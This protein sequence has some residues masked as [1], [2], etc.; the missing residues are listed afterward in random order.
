MEIK[1]EGVDKMAIKRKLSKRYSLAKLPVGW[2][3]KIFFSIHSEFLKL[4]VAVLSA[5]G[6]RPS[7]IERGV[8]VRMF[9][10]H[11]TIGIEGAK[12]D[13]KSGR[14]QPMRVL[15]VDSTTPWGSYL[16]QY[17]AAHNI[18]VIRYDAGGISQRLREKS[19][20]LWPR[21]KSLISAYTYRHFVGKSM[22][23]S[24]E[25]PEKIASTLGH[26]TDYAQTMYGRA[27][28]ARKSSGQHGVQVARATN[29]IRHSKKTDRL[30]GFLN[31]Q[32][33]DN[34]SSI[35]GDQT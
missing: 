19:R 22:K 30:N 6:C 12:V 20:E 2:R 3:E 29:A 16:S 23:E 8:K 24:G 34:A 11:L 9:H 33:H 4:A 28:G 21:R 7:E 26:A 5:T 10:G 31:A 1:A 17:I 13:L 35:A 14:G 15:V 32:S 18:V 27:G 25:P